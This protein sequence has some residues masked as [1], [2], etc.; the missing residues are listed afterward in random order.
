MDGT[1]ISQFA[2]LT[3]NVNGVTIPGRALEGRLARHAFNLAA[4]NDDPIYR[5]SLAG[6]ATA[7]RFRGRSLLLCTNHQLRGFDLEQVAMLTD[8]GGLVTSGGYV[9]YTINDSAD[10]SDLAAFDFTEP[11]AA[12]PELAARFFDLR[13]IPPPTNLEDIVCFLLT[14]F[15][16]KGQRYELEES[17]HLGLAR[18]CVPCLPDSLSADPAL[19]KV[20]AASPMAINPDGMSGGSAFV[21]CREGARF[22]AYFSGIIIRGGGD[23]FHILHP[24][25]VLN[26]LRTAFP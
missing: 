23:F 11:V 19:C 18:L 21:I 22:S 20:R 10:A 2:A 5:V 3:A 4:Y 12:H 16:S 6:S 1:I 14:G 13:A 17:N 8:N 24:G 9:S 7:I 25:L 26:F 15:P